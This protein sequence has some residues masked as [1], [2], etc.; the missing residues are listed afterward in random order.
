MS[1]LFFPVLPPCLSF[2]LPLSPSISISVIGDGLGLE[3]A[4]FA[5]INH[6]ER[7]ATGIVFPPRGVPVSRTVLKLR[8]AWNL[9]LKLH[10]KPSTHSRPRSWILPTFCRLVFI[11]HRVSSESR[12]RLCLAFV[13]MEMLRE[14]KHRWNIYEGFVKLR[15]GEEWRQYSNL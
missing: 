4:I 13:R 2:S 11:V 15:R 8:L 12:Q 10:W 1:I 6:A 7:V 14:S 3:P 5:C 9:K